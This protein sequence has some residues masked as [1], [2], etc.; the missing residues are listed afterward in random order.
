MALRDILPIQ[1]QKIWLYF[2]N[3]VSIISQRIITT[4]EINHGHSLFIKFLKEFQ[5]LYGSNIITPNMHYHL[6]LKNDMLNYGSWYSYW[7]Y[8]YKRLN[9]QIASFYTSGRTVELDML[10]YINQQ[11]EI[12]K[13]LDQIKPTL[14][15]TAQASLDYLQNEQLTKETLA[16]YNYTIPK[17]IEFQYSITNINFLLLDLKII[18]ED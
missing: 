3:A 13:L 16:I 4:K 7:Y 5:T 18:L 15:L 9:R 2:V 11:I 12:Y 10:N 14:T 17:I 6:H 1:N 8:A